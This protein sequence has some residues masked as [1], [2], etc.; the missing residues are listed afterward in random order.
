MVGRMNGPSRHPSRHAL[1]PGALLAMFVTAAALIALAVVVGVNH[2]GDDPLWLGGGDGSVSLETPPASAVIGADR[3]GEGRR[4][5]VL[6]I[7]SGPAAL[8]PG[9]G[10]TASGTA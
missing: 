7:G 9:M 2:G 3:G 10:P 8:V 5:A 1:L 4:R 6:Q